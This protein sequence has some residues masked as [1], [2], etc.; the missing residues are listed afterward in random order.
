[1]AQQTNQG[2]FR[3]QEPFN[4]Y[5]SYQPMVESNSANLFNYG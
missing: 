4:G 5:E 3:M 1:M 2:K